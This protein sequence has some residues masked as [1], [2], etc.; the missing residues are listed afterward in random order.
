LTLDHDYFIVSDKKVTDS[1]VYKSIENYVYKSIYA[2]NVLHISVSA[3]LH[4]FCL[5]WCY[6][7]QTGQFSKTA[8]SRFYKFKAPDFLLFF[9]DSV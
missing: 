5:F 6:V 3:M 7:F 1:S 4:A 2:V 9:H 8:E